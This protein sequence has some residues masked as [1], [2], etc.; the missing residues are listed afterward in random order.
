MFFAF[1]ANVSAQLEVDA[2][3]DTHVSGNLYLESDSNIIAT[4]NSLPVT[5]KV[6]G[7]LAGSTGSTGKSNVS[8][9]YRALYSNTTGGYN[10]AIG[11]YANIGAVNLSNATAIGYNAS[12]SSN[13]QVRI[14]NSN[15]TSIGG[16]AAWTNLSDG[17]AN[18][19]IRTN[20]PGLAFI[21]RLQP[22]T[23]NL[24]L[25]TIDGLL[26]INK[27]EKNGEDEIEESLPQELIEINK[28]AREAKEKVI[29]T[30]KPAQI[31]I[32]NTAGNVVR[33]IPII[34]GTDSITIEGGALSA[35]IY[36]YSL[37]VD[38][39]LID[40]KQLILTK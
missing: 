24:D 38:G 11:Y 9:G 37:Y 3:G 18:K 7:T 2:A 20:V 4:T 40:T 25:D 33:Q 5:F 26:K 16:Y 36:Y 10:T 27:T 35:G 8:F 23:Y 6:D 1:I 32:S 34:S 12:V 15:V 31:V 29:Q 19:N 13:N 30:G 17:R 28:K 22:V 39:R 14:G 21:N